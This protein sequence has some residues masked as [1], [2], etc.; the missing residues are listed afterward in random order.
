MS[1]ADQ[2]PLPNAPGIDRIQPKANNRLGAVLS[3][4][5]SFWIARQ[6]SFDRNAQSGGGVRTDAYSLIFFDST[7]TTCFEN[8]FTSSPEELLT[9]ALQ[10]DAGGAT[11]F[12]PALKRTQEVMISHW[13][14]ERYGFLLRTCTTFVQ[15]S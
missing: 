13:S 7:P 14:D 9:A 15:F 4:L 11:D 1:W 8:D 12:T 5:Y 10:Y 2:T 3:S 6:V